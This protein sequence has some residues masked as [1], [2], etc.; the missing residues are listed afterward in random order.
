MGSALGDYDGDGDLDWFVTAIFDTP[1][2]ITQPG[3]RLYRNNGNRT[4]TDVTTA[5]GV[6]ESGWGLGDRFFDYDND[7]RFD[8]MATDGFH[9]PGLPDDPTTLWRN[10]GDGTF[11]DVDPPRASPTRAKAAGC[12]T[13]DYDDDGDL[14]VLV[15]NHAAAPILYRNNGERCELAARR[16]RRDGLQ[17]RRHRARS[18]P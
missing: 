17:S 18:S 6:R 1:V 16:D 8:L 4:F 11:A 7:G 3:N 2:L 5:A 13:L 14:D 12:C 9:R 10:N 15:V